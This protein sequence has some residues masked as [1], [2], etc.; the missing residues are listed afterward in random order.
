MRIVI[1]G[2]S[3]AGLFAANLLARDGHQVSVHER[4]AEELSGRG[5]GI[6]THAELFDALAEAGVPREAKIGV[7]VTGR[8]TYDA[9]GGVV[10]EWPLPQIL[11]GWSRIHSLL[12][13]ALP[14]GLLRRGHAVSAFVQDAGGVTVRFADGAETRADLLVGADGVRSAIRGA[15]APELRPLPA[16]YIAWRGVVEEARMSKAAQAALMGHF[17]FCLPEGE[18]ML[19][20]PVADAEGGRRYNFVWYRPADAATLTAMLTDAQGRLHPEGIAPPRIRGE[21]LDEARAAARRNLAPAFAEVVALAEPLF[22]Q[23]I[24]DLHSTQIVFGRV[25]LIGDAAFVAR[26]HCGMGVTKAGADA[27][28]LARALRATPGDLPAALA[29]FAAGRLPI[30]RHIVD[31]A[32]HLGAYMQA[33]QNT[34]A[35]REMAARYRTPEAVMRETAVAP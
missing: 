24:I 4:A 18:Q 28:A 1:A 26:P 22:F 19:G 33:Q 11:A 29:G 30:G 34:T 35:E 5:A 12:G 6:V 14:A 27:V 7:S 13:A 31:H 10:G 25:A 16:G 32:R 17:A 15:L 20:Y 23:P 21:F 8:I 3:I 9:S 2:G